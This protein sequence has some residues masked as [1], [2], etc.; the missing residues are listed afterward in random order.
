MSERCWWG[1]ADRSEELNRHD[2]KFAKEIWREK[3]RVRRRVKSPFRISF[4]LLGISL[5]NLANLAS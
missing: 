3:E 4:F 2:A 1:G 5:A